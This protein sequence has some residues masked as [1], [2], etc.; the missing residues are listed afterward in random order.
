MTYGI[1]IVGND[2]GG[3]FIVADSQLDLLNYRVVQSGRAKSFTL[4]AGYDHI[5]VKDPSGASASGSGWTPI[6]VTS[7]SGYEGQLQNPNTYFCRVN[8][9]TVNFYGR[10]ITLLLSPPTGT[11]DPTGPDGLRNYGSV[12]VATGDF[13]VY[14]DYF[15]VRK[16]SGIESANELI[17]EDYGIKIVTSAGETAFD[18]RALITDKVFS[19]NTVLPPDNYT[20]TGDPLIT[21]P[22]DSYVNIEWSNTIPTTALFYGLTL[23]NT[24][25]YYIDSTLFSDGSGTQNWRNP[26][27]LFAAKLEAG[28]GGV[29][30]EDPP[31]SSEGSLSLTGSDYTTEGTSLSLTATTETSGDYHVNVYRTTGSDGEAGKDF[32]VDSHTFTGTSAAISLVPFDINKSITATVNYAR[33]FTGGYSRNLTSVFSR[34]DTTTYEGNFEGNFTGNFNRTSSYNRNYAANYTKESSYQRTIYYTAGYLGNYQRISTK[35]SSVPAYYTGTSTFLGNYEGTYNRN[36]TFN[37]TRTSIYTRNSITPASYAGNYSRY[38]NY[39]R[40]RN[41]IR[42]LADGPDLVSYTTNS[43]G[44][45]R[46]IGDYQRTRVSSF[47]GNYSRI[48]TVSPSYLGNYQRTST[49]SRTSAYDG[50]YNR[51]RNSAYTRDSTISPDYSD[52]YSRISTRTRYS[53]Y[54]K[55]STRTRL[56]TYQRTSTITSSRNFYRYSTAYY[57]GNYERTVSYE[58]NYQRGFVG[59]Y[60]RTFGYARAYQRFRTE[61]YMRNVTYLGNY[62][63]NYQRGV[64]STRNFAANYNRT[65]AGNYSGNVGYNRTFIGNFSNNDSYVGNYER[66]RESSYS[67]TIAGGDPWE[68]EITNGVVQ[69]AWRVKSVASGDDSFGDDP[70]GTTHDYFL[71]LV[72]NGVTILNVSY[73]S[74][75]EADAVDGPYAASN[76]KYYWRGT[77]ESTT[78]FSKDYKIAETTTL[79]APSSNVTTDYT[80]DFVGNYTRTRVVGASSTRDRVSSFSRVVVYTRNRTSSYLGNYTGNFTPLAYAG[81][82]TRSS[83]GP[84]VDYWVDGEGETNRIYSYIRNFTGNYS[85]NFTRD[86]GYNRTR[87]SVYQRFRPADIPYQRIRSQSYLGDYSRN[88]GGNYVGDYQRGFAGNYTG[89]YQRSFFGNFSGQYTGNYIGGLNYEGNY[90]RGFVGNYIGDYNRNFAGNYVGDYTRTSTRGISYLG[91]YIGDRDKNVIDN[92]TRTREATFTRTR[93]SSL[94]YQ[95]NYERILSFIGD[96]TGNYSGNYTRTRYSAIGYAGTR[97]YQ[98][99][100]TGDYNRTSTVTGNSTKLSSYNRDIAYTGNYTGDYTRQLNRVRTSIVTRTSVFSRTVGTDYTGTRPAYYAGTYSRVYSRNSVINL[101]GTSE[102]GFQGETFVAV[103]R[104]GKDSES[105]AKP[106]GQ[107]NEIDTADFTLYDDDTGTYVVTRSISV[108]PHDTSHNVQISSVPLEGSTPLPIR[109][110]RGSNIVSQDI[111][112]DSNTLF[113]TTVSEVPPSGDTYTYTVK[114]YNGINWVDAA[115]YNVYSHIESQPAPTPAPDPT[116][117]PAPTPTY[118]RSPGTYSRNVIEH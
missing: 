36:S 25:S 38:S 10:G 72:W 70:A 95:G 96:F 47:E 117:A 89:D 81:N 115:T 57:T 99:N 75:A 68:Y 50:T 53:A 63:G 1:K 110:Y 65:F 84:A 35:I 12:E 60:E 46:Y 74:F 112:L 58:G 61:Y 24:Q 118:T 6:S 34:G 59:T 102:M 15:V 78:F 39:G 13:D 69:Y 62:I 8:G 51:T 107:L 104:A 44:V 83:L 106:R 111:S 71:Q 55:V 45:T 29:D 28:Q 77:N 73:Y 18:S 5:F 40:T 87:I 17:D 56:V 82:Y 97:T 16:V 100:Y 19:I 32:V 76:G 64:I 3:D 43:V 109:I 86:V 11:F 26:Y 9:S 48:S 37:F 113:T 90:Q 4:D 2:N 31:Q 94:Y 66:T 14:L 52:V 114:V 23:D 33:S 85:R 27:A 93:S 105:V 21:Y 92:Y 101:G 7:E 49:R 42:E 20:S 41:S 98:G 30:T 54:S 67:R 22:A 80:R 103:L 108:R 79:T 88:Y 91:D 116:P